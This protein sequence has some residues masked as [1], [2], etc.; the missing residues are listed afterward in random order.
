[1]DTPQEA[2]NPFDSSQV[3]GSS[4]TSVEDAFFG[5]QDQP[6][7]EAPTQGQPAV[8]QTSEVEQPLEAKNDQKRFEYWQSQAAQKENQLAQMQ[9]QLNEV[10]QQTMQQQQSPTPEPEVERFPDPPEKPTKPRT[11]SREEAFADPNSDS[12]RYLDEVEDWRDNMSEYNS[13]KQE[14]HT[15]KIQERYDAQERIRQE[16]I[17]RQQ[18]ANDYSQKTNQ[19]KEHL[20][21]H[22]GFEGA[23]ADEFIQVM[24]DPNSLN[25]DNLVQLHRM[26]KGQNQIENSGPSADFSQVQRTQQIPSPMGVQTGQGDGNN[27]K[28][29]EDQIMDNILSDYKSKNPW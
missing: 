27:A 5:P 8:E 17:A 18:A 2:T 20:V 3:E 25:L 22:Y 28:S 29:E 15:A 24:S 11:F 16:D 14:Y 26:Q 1:M 21:G 4:Q 9:Q 12:A 10:Q 19:I 13:L 6:A 23:E 7:T